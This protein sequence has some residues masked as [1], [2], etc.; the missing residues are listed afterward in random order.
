MAK[1]PKPKDMSDEELTTILEELNRRAIGYL[2]D[3]VSVDQDDNLDR[4]LGRPY[5]DEEEGRS[6][7]LS[8][9]VAEVVD[10]ALPDLL[11]PFVSGERIVEFSPRRRQDD[12]FCEQASDLVQY[13]FMEDNP[14][15]LVLHDTVK[16]ALIQKLG[17]IKTVWRDEEKT[18]EETLT[19]ISAIHLAELQQDASIE[20]AEDAI[21]AEP[22]QSADPEIMAAF[23]DGQTYTVHI[24][25]KVNAGCVQV[26][27]IPPEEFKVS[28]RSADLENVE[29][30]CHETEKTRGDLIDM[31]FEPDEVMLLSADR[32]RDTDRQD[33]RFQDEDRREDSSRNK[34]SDILTLVE[35][36]PRIDADGDGK[37]ERRQIFRVGKRILSNEVVSEHPF[38][39]WTADRIPHRLI[40]LALADKVK[41]TQKIKTHLTRNF[42]DNVY[43]ANNPRTEVPEQAERGDG[44]TIEDLLNVRI[45]GIVRTKQGGMLTPIETPDRSAS[46]L[47]AIVYMDGVREQ[48]SGVVK[49]GMAVSSEAIDPKSATE[50]R[51]EDRN[52]QVRKRLMCRMIAE[53]LLVPV[54]KKI[55]RNLVRYQ[56]TPRDIKLRDE[57]VS[58]DPRSWNADLKAKV[59]TGL[60]YANK[61]E[62]I[63]A[64]MAVL[65]V[66][67][68]MVAGGLT[69]L[70]RPKHLYA[71]AAKLVKATGLRFPEQF[72]LDPDSQEGQQIAQE[73]ASKPAEDP[74]MVEVQGKLQMKQMEMQMDAQME[75]AKA[76]RDMQITM[77]QAQA[78]MAIEE[79]KTD[80]DF[81]AKLMQINA[82]YQLKQQQMFAEIALQRQQMGFEAHMSTKQQEID[83]ANEN[84]RIEGANKAAMT[85]AKMKPIKFGGRVG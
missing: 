53:T 32:R 10:W 49:N 3:E 8:M 36:Y 20:I 78:K 55:L 11:E 5:G 28:S 44:E 35:E 13:V 7:A 64:A 14:G 2:S 79:R 15:F 66:Q 76:E 23:P 69:T 65:G 1:K 18:E 43:L 59:S 40:G 47:Q 12:Q 45:G 56:D 84:K 9:D 68:R 30:V 61:D 75:A 77:L 22:V 51:K 29:Y 82:E 73:E 6:T 27:S 58:M 16:T 71:S 50:A 33:S 70:V 41:Q 57:W 46:A 74:K 60:G 26:M 62:E 67:E 31:G 48:Q 4:Y 52:E 21:S 25:R 81:R 37:L 72:F 42:L 24:T 85:K 17:V 38:D 34:L 54:F 80:F 19:G 63:N 83:A 39:A